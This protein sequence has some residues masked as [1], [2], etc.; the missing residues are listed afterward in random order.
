MGSGF[1]AF[2]GCIDGVFQQIAQNDS[3]ICRRYADVLWK[4]QFRLEID[5]GIR[6]ASSVMLQQRINSALAVSRPPSV[7]MYIWSADCT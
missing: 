3:H 7:V 5:R 1:F 2:K 6:N 4:F